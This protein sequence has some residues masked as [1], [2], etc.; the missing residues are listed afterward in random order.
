MS[1]ATQFPTETVR[2]ALRSYESKPQKTDETGPRS[3]ISLVKTTKI[4]ASD[5]SL[6][7][8][9]T[10]SQEFFSETES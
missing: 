4:E 8:F 2:K 10:V 7:P 6:T 1:M 9:R 5:V 3:S